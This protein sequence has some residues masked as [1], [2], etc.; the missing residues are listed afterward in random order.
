MSDPI[1][2]LIEKCL[3]AYSPK[4]LSCYRRD[5]MDFRDY[6]RSEGLCWFPAR[7]VAVAS[8]IDQMCQ[9]YVTSTVRRKIGAIRFLHVMNDIDTPTASAAVRLAYR[10][11]MR[12]NRRQPKRAAPITPELLEKLLSSC[13]DDLA[14]LRDR[15]LMRV[16]YES[17]ARAGEIVAIQVQDLQWGDAAARLL[18]P[19]SKADIEG[20]GRWVNFSPHVA[21]D[22]RVWALASGIRSGALFRRVKGKYVGKSALDISSVGRMLRRRQALVGDCGRGVSGH[23]FRVG[24]AQRLLREGR[25][26]AEIMICG[27]WQSFNSMVGYLR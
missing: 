4:T 23:S 7:D 22:I 21:A 19:R 15:A 9:A 24:G 8:Y 3:G 13:G 25:S 10:R 17:L 2:D 26:D 20:R 12:R 27:G 1:Q 14:G 16:G 6:C 11:V 5:L 18:I